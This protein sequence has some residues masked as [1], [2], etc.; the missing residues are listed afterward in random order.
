MAPSKNEYQ[1]G[2]EILNKESNDF[3]SKNQTIPPNIKVLG[4]TEIKD[5]SKGIGV[6][7]TFSLFKKKYGNKISATTGPNYY[8]FVI[9][10]TTPAALLGDWLTSLY[11]QCSPL[12]DV[13]NILEKETLEQAKILFNISSEFKGT[14][15]S[16][17]TVSNLVNLAIARQWIGKQMELDIA[18]NGIV[19]NNIKVYSATPHSS[20]SKSL[21]IIG[22][23]RDNLQI[24]KTVSK[25]ESI[26]TDQLEKELQKDSNSPSIVVANAGTVNTGDF[27]DFSALK[28]LK[29]KYNFWLHIDA[30]FGG[31]ANCTSKHKYLLNSWNCADSI[32]IDAHKWLNVPY[33]SAFQFTKHIHLQS[34]VFQNGNAPYLDSLT[35]SFINLV[36]ENSRR[37]RALPIWFS[38]QSY[39]IDGISEII[40]RNCE[41][42]VQI[43]NWID[44]S[45]FL[46][47]MAEVKLNIVCFKVSEEMEFSTAMYLKAIN[48][49]NKVFMT[50]TNFQ[51]EYAIR[52]AFSNW[53]TEFSDLNDL[54]KLL[55][56]VKVR[57]VQ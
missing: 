29:E 56:E 34:Q 46:I 19:T 12:T 15:V 42:A 40:E 51:G 31:F 4:E 2:L 5:I 55:R 8:G 47:L 32:T 43:G 54:I 41:M 10:G 21:S 26:D 13:T 48:E 9:G 17:A 20:V 44:E 37:W 45:E 16:G 50:P 18:N 22:I 3:L 14:L 53:S 24:V 1:K 57:L 33:D 11:D 49:T 30:A 38:F 35:D 27:D 6:E 36:P 23:G 52:I 39:G 7:N 28:K 25:R